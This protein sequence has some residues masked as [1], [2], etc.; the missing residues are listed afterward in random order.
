MYL[1]VDCNNFYASC[2]RVFQPGLRE[3]PIVVLSNN[4]GCIIARS[5][6]AKALGIAMGQPY[7]EVQ[8]LCKQQNVQVFSSNYALY[9]DMSNRV[10]SVLEA[11]W[12][13]LE[14]YSIDE[15]F[16]EVST[17]S[18]TAIEKLSHSLIKTIEK[19]T[20]IPVSIGAGKTK[21]LAK[22]ANYL[23][24]KHFNSRYF[25]IE[26][27]PHHLKTMKAANVWGVGRR[28]AERLSKNAV[29]SA[30]DLKKMPAELIKKHYNITLAKTVWELQ[31]EPCFLLEA[32][33]PRKSIRSSRSFAT[34]QHSFA[35]IHGA[36]MAYCDLAFA[37][38]RA[39]QSL[40]TRI[41][42]FL[43]TDPFR[44][45]HGCLP[46]QAAR[47]LLS[48]TDDLRLISRLAKQCLERLFKEGVFY[49]KVGVCLE[50]LR[51]KKNVQLSLWQE[52]HL[53]NPEKS[54]KL[55]GVYDKINQRYGRNTIKL[56]SNQLTSSNSMRAFYRSPR[57][58]TSW[59]ELVFVRLCPE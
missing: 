55:M 17:L 48:P 33:E 3:R 37:K 50:D 52:E 21:T 28:W 54:Q 44:N 16:L 41:S 7:F 56:A 20:G 12:P 51:D 22:C 34:P 19:S 45:K 32:P 24:K 39:Q 2:E 5:N 53:S 29:F 46:S 30:F 49:K 42:V 36:L 13:T 58:T 27:A 23:A 11:H 18:S 10:M 25:N 47:T 4:D 26:S 40:T 14:I 8:T 1:I 43:S 35:N 31:G 38:L 59:S 6:E 57:Y 15:A 9:G